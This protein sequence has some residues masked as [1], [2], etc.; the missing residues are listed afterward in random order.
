M[1]ISVITFSPELFNH[2]INYIPANYL[3]TPKHIVPEWYFLPFYALLRSIPNKIIG[4]V[5]MFSSILVL[6]LL[7]FLD[8]NRY[9]YIDQISR[10]SFF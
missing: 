3:V 5:C 9:I 10:A 6:F 8:S 1:Y 4:I 2:S 7:P